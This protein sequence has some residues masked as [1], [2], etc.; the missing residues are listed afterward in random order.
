[1]LLLLENEHGVLLFRGCVQVLKFDVAVA[2]C[3]VG[4]RFKSNLIRQK[5]DFTG[6]F[7]P[8]SPSNDASL[9][10]GNHVNKYV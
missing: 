7:F 10:P 8:A 2:L 1:M 5:S 9:V 3:F 4:W 6:D